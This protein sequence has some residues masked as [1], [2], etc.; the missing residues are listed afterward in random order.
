MAGKD[1]R[2]ETVGVAS[3]G[4]GVLSEHLGRSEPGR[5]DRI[6]ASGDGRGN[7]PALTANVQAPLKKI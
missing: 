2:D 4:F 6:A 3:C 1:G 7:P 5:A